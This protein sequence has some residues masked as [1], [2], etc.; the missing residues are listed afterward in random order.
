MTF[1]KL[2][3]SAKI[4]SPTKEERN[5]DNRT[6]LFN[7]IATGDFDAIVVPQSFMAF[8]PDSEE[9]KKA[10]IQKRIDDFEEAID[11]IEDKALQERLKREAKSMRDSLEGIKK[12]KN[13]KGKAKTAE[14]ITL[15]HASRILS[16]ATLA[17]TD[18][19][20]PTLDRRTDNVMTFEQMGVDALF[21]DEAHNY[22]KIGFPSKMSNVKGID[23]SASQKANSM[24]LKSPMD[25]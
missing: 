25:I 16:T 1:Y 17:K 10:Y 19:F 23:T 15:S 20:L 4:L 6:R 14:T 24:L 12:G 11:R 9:R 7:L 3:P 5:A 22:K 13:V 8:I 21:I 2:Y 18:A